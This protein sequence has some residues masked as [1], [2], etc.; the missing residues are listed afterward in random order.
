M[1]NQWT[2]EM[3]RAALRLVVIT[4]AGLARGRTHEELSRQALRG[5]ATCVQLRDK[6]LDDAGLL[7]AA[8]QIAPLCHSAGALF[9]VNDRLDVGRAA[10]SDGCH[11]G[12]GDLDL[13]AARQQ[14]PRPAVLGYSAGNAEDAVAAMAA[15]A[16]Y[17]GAGPVFPTASKAD[18][19]PV[20]GLD[21]LAAVVEASSLPV[22]AI[23]GIHHEN[24]ASCMAAGAAG[25][26]VIQAVVAAATVAPAAR[27][28]RRIVDLASSG[29]A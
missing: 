10:A 14:W 8:E 3:L 1:T 15:G 25:V 24:A 9:I 4:D 17:L 21:G 20:I 7:A 28:L 26:A 5:G 11:L 19:R 27:Q 29:A 2:N 23:G 18:A 22:V 16:D 12:P 13:A 6:G